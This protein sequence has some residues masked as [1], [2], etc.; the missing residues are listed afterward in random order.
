LEQETA[1]AEAS[2]LP[3]VLDAVIPDEGRM[4]SFFIHFQK[5]AELNFSIF[6][7]WIHLIFVFLTKIFHLGKNKS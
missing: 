1:P 3:E 7:F 6:N 2:I 5:M 4:I